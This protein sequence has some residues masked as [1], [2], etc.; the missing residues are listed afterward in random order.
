MKKCS[1]FLLM[2]F[3]VLLPASAQMS[4]QQ[5][6]KFIQQEM[7]AGTS[8]S[9]IVTKLMQKGVK[10]EQIRRLRNQYDKD[11]KARGAAGAADA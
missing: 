2:L 3:V 10:I 8:Q 9:Q 6:M 4:D 5:V 11:L 1:L 7:K